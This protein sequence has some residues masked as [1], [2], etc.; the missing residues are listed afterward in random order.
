MAL[1]GGFTVDN[2]VQ[3]A[4]A[5]GGMRLNPAGLTVDNLVRIAAAASGK[6][7]QLTILSTAG[8]TV[9]NLVRI[10]AAGKGTVV[11]DD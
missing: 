11:F 8:M 1:R 10:A 6:G 5:G 4:A 2:L 9:D 3:I 7:S